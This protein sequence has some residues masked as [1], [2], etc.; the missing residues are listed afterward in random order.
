MIFSKK[1]SSFISIITILTLICLLLIFYRYSTFSSL[2]YVWDLTFA[3]ATHISFSFIIDWVSTIFLLTLLLI[4]LAVAL[5]S[6]NYIDL[7]KHQNQFLFTLSTFIASIIFFIPRNNFLTIIIGW[8]GL[9]ISSFLLIIY[10]QT[11]KGLFSGI[12]TRFTNRIGDV[13][14]L[15]CLSVFFLAGSRSIINNQSLSRLSLFTSIILLFILIASFTKSAQTPFSSW[16]PAAIAAPTPVSALVHSSTLVTA[17]IF[18]IIRVTSSVKLTTPLMLITLLTALF[19]AVIAGLAATIEPDVKK[20]IALSTLSQL[21][22]I[23][24]RIAINNNKV[25]FLHLISHARFKA[26]LFIR[27]GWILVI[28]SH[29]QDIRDLGE[30]N[31]MSN[32]SLIIITLASLRLIALPFLSGFYSKDI[33]LENY[34][35]KQFSLTSLI[36]V[37]TAT[38]LTSIYSIKILTIIHTNSY[39]HP[40][41][42]ICLPQPLTHNL[43]AITLGTGRVCLSSFLLWN[44]S[45]V[46]SHPTI[47]PEAKF[48]L[49]ITLV[50]AILYTLL[51][52]NTNPS[53]LNPLIIIPTEINLNIRSL[54]PTSHSLTALLLNKTSSTTNLIIEDI[55]A[56]QSTSSIPYIITNTLAKNSSNFL[57]SFNFILIAFIIATLI[58]ST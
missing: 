24:F 18:L 28:I 23:I 20:L 30:L 40:P 51:S 48:L 29:K 25:A 49:T 39:S 8:D 56:H 4:T 34:F 6:F 14:I 10:Y 17:G 26:L 16:L 41:I 1:S 35:T 53:T 32:S 33:I 43:A 50:L 11:P 3:K 47:M 46:L 42:T 15:S 36:L 2:T 22:M 52:I 21:G 58:C 55:W 27:A 13:L 9:G 44:I 5:F 37:L 31:L 7:D 12:V 57:P 54:T 45:P 19:T 38:A